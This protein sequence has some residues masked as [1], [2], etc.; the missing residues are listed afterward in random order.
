MEPTQLAR[1]IVAQ[2]LPNGSAGL[3]V[4]IEH[5]LAIVAVHLAAHHGR[6]IAGEGELLG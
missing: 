6:D 1:Q 4:R 2:P 5:A 3:V